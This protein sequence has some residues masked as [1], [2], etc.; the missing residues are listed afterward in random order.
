VG[1]D[2]DN[3]HGADRPDQY[4][5]ENS[6]EIIN[7]TEQELFG[8]LED[9]GEQSIRAKKPL[10]GMKKGL[11]IA[12][13]ALIL[14]V[15]ATGV[16]ALAFFGQVKE[17]QRVLLDEVTFETTYAIDEVFPEHIVNIG[18]LGFDRGWNRESMGEYLFRPDMLAVLSINF[19]SGQISVVRIPRDS[20]VPIHGMNGFHDKINHSFYYGYI[21][22]SGDDPEAE[23][24]RYTLQTVS[25]VLGGI[26]IHYHLSVDMYS[27]IELVDAMG[28]VYYEVE[29]E[30]IDKYWEIGR[31]LVPA[32]PQM[33]DGK[34]F[35][36][37]LQYRDDKT[38][39]DY[40]RI[41]RQMNLLKETFYYLR[42]QGRITDIPATY[43]IYKD[44][45]ETDLSYKQIAALAY[46]ARDLN[47]SDENLN[48]YTVNGGGHMKDGIWYQVIFDDQRLQIIKDVFG[49]DAEPWPPIVLVDSP[50]YLEEQ[51]EKRRL[52]ELGITEENDEDEDEN[53]NENEDDEIS[54]ED[55]DDETLTGSEDDL[56][57]E[58]LEERQL[59]VV[60]DLRGKTV[61]QARTILESEL[62]NM[63]SI[64]TRFYFLLEKGLVIQSVPLP[65]T[66][67]HVGETINLVVSDGPDPDGT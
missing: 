37:Y 14:L 25:N 19:D 61:E 50:E 45:V 54:E 23:G 13:V 48:F 46:Y 55:S 12:A 10:R 24:I 15:L 7:P 21:Y 16:Y 64:E 47:I 56:I 39:Q 17:T 53:E 57:N 3:E 60:P 34:T 41:D 36:R 29:E 26:P 32:G 8:E 1:N 30:I 5:A 42:E 40:G 4:G 51:E 58:E 27:I 44:Y 18:L 67:I 33:M 31:V 6:D 20:Y 35:L 43:R 59:A 11:L 22:G 52:E 2:R 49:F 63:G 65:G 28:G 66:L 38:N 62:F 9:A